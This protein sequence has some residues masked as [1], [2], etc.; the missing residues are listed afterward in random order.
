MV[1]Q[2]TRA[3]ETDRDIQRGV[4]VGVTYKHLDVSGFVLNPDD[5]KPIVAIALRLSF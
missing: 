2:R 3:Y 1:T 5:D 4:L